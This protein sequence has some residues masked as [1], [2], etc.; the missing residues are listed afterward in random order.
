[1]TTF[2]CEHGFHRT[3]QG[4]KWSG[5]AR[6]LLARRA[7]RGTQLLEIDGGC[8]QCLELA[9][10]WCR[11]ER[12]A[13]RRPRVRAVGLSALQRVHLA[14]LH[15]ALCPQLPEDAAAQ[16]NRLLQIDAQVRIARRR[17]RAEALIDPGSASSTGSNVQ[18]KAP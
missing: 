7:H 1:M 4:A 17:V 18:L 14:L 15:G 10:D 3:P 5:T 6:R 16:R 11:Q 9:V 2:R 12:L 13:G 8:P